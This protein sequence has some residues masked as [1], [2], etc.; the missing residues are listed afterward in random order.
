[1]KKICIGI[2]VQTEAQSL[3]ATLASLR[4]HTSHD[5]ELLL[6]PDGPYHA[7]AEALASLRDL[8]QFGTKRPS[9][10]PAS[11][12]RLAT[13]TDADVLVL[14]ESGAQVARGWLDYL[15][16]AL[17]ADE[18][19][20]LAGPTT[21]RCWNE[22]GVYERSGG[23]SVE[24]ERTAQDALCRFGNAWRT[25]EPLYSLADFCYVVRREVIH[26]IGAADESYGLGPCWEMDYNIRAARAGWRGVWACAAYVHRSPFTLRR[27][28]LEARL[29]ETNKHIYQNKF[30][31]ARLRGEKTG[32]RSHCR[33]DECPNFAPHAL[34]HLSHAFKPAPVANN[35]AHAIDYQH[36]TFINKSAAASTQYASPVEPLVSCIMPTSNRR[37]F[38]PQA[39]RCFLRQDY[40]NLELLIVDDGS[41]S[42][43]DCVPPDDAR[44][45]Y[46][47][48]PSKGTIGAKRNYACAQARGQFIAHWDDDDW[49]PRWR[50]REQL[51][52]MQERGADLCGTSR[53]FYYEAE[54]GR[55][56]R[57]EYAGSGKLW[58]AGSTLIYSKSLWERNK[59][60]D[61][62]VGEDTRFVWS[63]VKK[64]ICDLANHALCIATI[65]PDNTSRKAT[66][67]AFWHAQASASIHELLGDDLSF[68]HARELSQT[69]STLPLISCIMPTFN[70]RPFVRLALK[71]FLA[72]DY[73]NKE[74]VVIDDGTDKVC[75]VMEG[76]A[77]VRY[78]HLARRASIGSKRNLACRQARGE[79]IAHWD[80][81]DWYAPE[82]L[83]YQAAP[84]ISGD[85]DL[86]GLANTF[87]LELPNGNF[88][89]TLPQLHPKMFVG[90]VHGGTLVYR[91]SLLT[92][93]VRYPET[94]LAEDAALIRQALR[95]GKRLAKLS[96]PGI[97]VYVRHGHNAWREFAPGIFLDLDGWERVEP[98][99]AFPPETVSTYRDA[100][101][102]LLNA[103][104]SNAGLIRR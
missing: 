65:H 12:N 30:C 21:N 25:L 73:P 52:A 68:Y 69:A 72:Q 93:G 23:T 22:Q 48:L 87:V 60:P 66:N 34:V 85:A 42:I 13:S 83:R 11:F 61:I 102:A 74:L 10:A 38:I 19:N 33:G 6:L 54:T 75:D 15:L 101:A 63:A 79:I 94:N 58:V 90:D 92:Q 98:P 57:Y 40:P 103:P 70:R 39:L 62:Q 43:A 71:Y 20:G 46:L 84:I 104:S 14:L 26:S 3:S 36:A 96:N 32:Y 82:R 7:T 37:A 29:F 44:I 51:H 50:V 64:T 27:A 24:I 95:R 59:F 4:A 1:M 86:T 99:T 76:V 45:R 47:R 77:N 91:K 18:R 53:L 5:V 80:D 31:G 16:A 55:A 81:D 78:V 28:R 8:P 89:A 41:D 17:D 9:G 88:W 97:F 49:Y 2:H 56:W 100:A 35:S 67:G